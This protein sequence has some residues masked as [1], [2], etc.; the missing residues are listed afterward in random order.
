VRLVLLTISAILLCG[1][2][3]AQAT[4]Y[5][6]VDD[7]GQ[8]HFGDSIPPKYQRK[9][10]YELNDSGIV[11]ERRA[12]QKTAEERREERM[13]VRERA[14]VLKLKKEKR[15]RDRVLLD[16]YTTER[17][18]ILAR[19]ARLD[20]VRAQIQLAESIV[21]DSNKK[22]AS[23]EVRV[24]EI[25]ESNREVPT[26]LYRDIE[27]HQ[28]QIALYNVVKASHE[29]RQNTVSMQF[30]NYIERF[31]ALKQEQQD[32]RDK[33]ARERALDW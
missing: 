10:H 22:I 25:K 3:A 1:L 30:N 12:A 23:L 15:Q 6:W 31:R 27:N 18:L 24:A 13:L 20:A 21:R 8:M 4:T 26:N 5:K 16:T 19:D 32:R 29:K 11:I 28:Q 14:M 7:K 33:L 9:A 17:D 2:F